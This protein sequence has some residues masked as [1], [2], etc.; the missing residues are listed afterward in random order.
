VIGDLK[1]QG[2]SGFL[3]LS[4]DFPVDR[5]NDVISEINDDNCDVIDSIL[6]RKRL[7]K[8]SD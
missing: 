4:G 5:F 6:N 7:H 3:F 2:I 8:K 1:V